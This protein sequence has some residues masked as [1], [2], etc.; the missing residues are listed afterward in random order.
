MK[1][2][3]IIVIALTW[4]A[5]AHATDSTMTYIGTNK[6][7]YK[8]YLNLKDSSI[9]VEVPAGKFIMGSNID[10]VEKPIHFV[11]LDKYF[12]GK[13]EVTVKQFK[14]FCKATGKSMPEQP[15]WNT[16]DNYPV[17]KVTWY[18]AKAYCDWAGLRLPTEAEWEQAARGKDGRVYPW[19]DKWDGKKCNHGSNPGPHDDT[20]YGTDNSDGYKYTA[21]VGSYTSGLSP[22]GAYDMA[23]NVWEWCNDWFVYGYPADSIYRN[24]TGPTSGSLRILR[25]GSWFSSDD[26]YRSSSRASEPPSYSGIYFGFRPTK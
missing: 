3:V 17:V 24:P 16:G 11:S 19:G 14:K 26:Y 6:Q 9:L 12:I 7:G 8:E 25:G 5:I 1:R 18:D 21:P 15:N 4:S 22:Y 23:G 10:D 13:Y 2:I 20:D